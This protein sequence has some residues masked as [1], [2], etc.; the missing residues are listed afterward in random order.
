MRKSFAALASLAL[1]SCALSQSTNQIVLDYNKDFAKSRNEVLL[2]N[3][4]RAAAREPLQFSTMGQVNGTVGNSSGISIPFTNV[5]AGGKNA[6][7]PTLTVSDAINP[8][9]TISPLASKD[10]ASGILSPMRME[11]IQLF[12]HNGWDPE[13]LLPLIVGG[14]V[15][16][17]DGR[18]LLN[19]GEYLTWD[20]IAERWVPNPQ[21]EAFKEFFYQSAASFSVGGGEA[22]QQKYE[23]GGKEALSTLKDGVG[24][25]YTIVGVEDGSSGKK[26]MAVQPVH[27]GQVSG[28]KIRQLCDSIPVRRD[29]RGIVGALSSEAIKSLSGAYRSSES[30]GAATDDDGRIVFRSVG[31]IIQHLGESHR[32]RY[33]AGAQGGD[34]LTYVNREG[35]GQ[36]LFKLDWGLRRAP[37]AVQTSFQG[38]LFYVPRMMLGTR[39][40]S[41]RTLKTLSFVDQL[42]ALQTS[43]SS[44]RGAQ[45]VISVNQ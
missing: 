28:L 4:L 40:S 7:S 20:R 31:S 38:V 27:A 37:K 6:V 2:L 10:F 29:R 17:R 15:C 11:T 44:I 32:I 1:T 41:D 9:I 8:S 33:L 36:I 12:L 24:S 23:L 22:L 43:E 19:G 13:F 14:V 3:V 21:Y 45:P 16:P 39:E 30:G 26:F 35:T 25:A 18:L 42:I 34:G 5:I